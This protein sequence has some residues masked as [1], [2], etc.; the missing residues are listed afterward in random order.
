M[1][2]ATLRKP[3]CG[4]LELASLRKAFKARARPTGQTLDLR[5]LP[6]LELT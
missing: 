4:K 6:L 5:R 2:L 1:M 3:Q